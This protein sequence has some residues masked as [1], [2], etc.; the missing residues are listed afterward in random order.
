MNQND[1]ARRL[2]G[3][4]I[5]RGPQPRTSAGTAEIARQLLAEQGIDPDSLPAPEPRREPAKAP[6]SPGLLSTLLDGRTCIYC[7]DSADMICD[8]CAAKGDRL[9]EE[10]AAAEE[11][12]R[13]AARLEIFRDRV[14]GYFDT[15]FD[16]LPD[17]ICRRAVADWIPS[18]LGG[19]RGLT[20][21]GPGKTGKT[22][23]A[24]LI[25]RREHD[26]G[27]WVEFRQCGELRQEVAQHARNGEFAR[28]VKALFSC[29]VL[30]LDDF[31]N[32]EFT[33]TAEEF[34][35]SLLERRAITRRRTIVTSQYDA[36]QLGELFHTRQMADAVLRRIGIEFVS[37][38]HTGTG[39]FKP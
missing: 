16:L 6:E 18:N 4:E 33:R 35:L 24:V 8:D 13:Q 27:E 39:D 19:R 23:S 14:G 15:E 34:F 2:L 9:R 10:Q 36:K 22:R 26:R 3:H 1:I 17:T 29:G 5:Y 7:G 37:T 31:G 20:I 12:K 28:G 11:S 38:A 32:H 25:S 21:V 30:I